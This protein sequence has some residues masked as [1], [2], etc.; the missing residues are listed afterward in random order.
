MIMWILDEQVGFRKGRRCV[1][2]LGLLK[3]VK[4]IKGKADTCMLYFLICSKH[5][6]KTDKDAM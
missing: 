3:Y 5:N 1:D 2:Q 4:I 6:D